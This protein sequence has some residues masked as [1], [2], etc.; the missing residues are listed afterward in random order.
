[1]RAGAEADRAGA[2]RPRAGR[3]PRAGGGRDVGTDETAETGTGRSQGPGLGK[4]RAPRA[5]RSYGKIK[6]SSRTLP[7][8]C[9]AASPTLAGGSWLGL[10]SSQPAGLG[11][12]GLAK[13]DGTG[14]R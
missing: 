11:C 5:K 7:R 4:I 10:G 8:P 13:P 12:A 3:R 6:Q 9:A 1:M 14:C 2:S